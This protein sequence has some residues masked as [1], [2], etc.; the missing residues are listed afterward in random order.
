MEKPLAAR[1]RKHK[2]R[3]LWGDSA[4]LRT[5][6]QQ[7]SLDFSTPQF[8][9]L[10]D[11]PLYLFVNLKV[12]I[13]GNVCR[14]EKNTCTQLHTE[15]GIMWE[16]YTFFPPLLSGLIVFLQESE[17]SDIFKKTSLSSPDNDAKH[18]ETQI[19]LQTNEHF[20]FVHMLSPSQRHHPTPPPPPLPPH[21][22]T[23]T[24]FAF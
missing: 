23:H 4:Y 11:I 15:R 7:T 17:S 13:W 5:P 2:T 22:H 10:L 3:L 12:Q 9:K 14:D 6:P 1:G 21:T 8:C 20:S 16:K 19:R 18:T 24:L